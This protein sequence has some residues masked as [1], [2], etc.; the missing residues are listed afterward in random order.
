M[1]SSS[2]VPQG[3]AAAA[4]V[5]VLPG[6]GS[7]LARGLWSGNVAASSLNFWGCLGSPHWHQGSSCAQICEATEKALVLGELQRE[8]VCTWKKALPDLSVFFL[9]FTAE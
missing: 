9:S 3:R 6:S 7:A 2:R 8:H 1:R 5:M 4:R